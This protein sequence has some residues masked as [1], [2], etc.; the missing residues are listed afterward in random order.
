MGNLTQKIL[1]IAIPT[2]NRA[3]LLDELLIELIDQIKKFNLDEVVEILVSNNNSEDN[4]EDI[5]KRHQVSNKFI[6]YNRNPLNIGAKSN[7]IKSVELSSGEYC[8]VL[9]DDDR[10]RL[11]CLPDI[12]NHIKNFPDT[13]IVI[14]KSGSKAAGRFNESA[15]SLNELL[16]NFFW[17][18]GN[19]GVFVMRVSFMKDLLKKVNY[20][21]FNECWVQIQVMI[22]GMTT[23]KEL[24]CYL[25]EFHVHRASIHTEVM[26]YNSFYLWRTCNIELLNSINTIKPLIESET[27]DSARFYLRANISQQVFNILQ[28]AVFIDD[29]SIRK[30]TRTHIL[31]NLF[32]YSNYEKIV[33]FMVIVAIYLPKS[34]SEFLSDIFIRFTRGKAGLDKKNNFVNHELEKKARMEA[35][36]NNQL[37][38][39]EFEV[40]N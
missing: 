1:S 8:I 23:N 14:D 18:M 12:L 28:C 4:T 39:L 13:G 26:V 29:E 35:S 19:A 25:K 9:G 37:R 20:E 11:D 31:K 38:T 27:Y 7:L 5:V 15:I 21:Y 24:K 17:Y 32:L 30:K 40:D 2:W 33:F 10:I 36:K 34:I 16:R 22:L 3:N 6:E